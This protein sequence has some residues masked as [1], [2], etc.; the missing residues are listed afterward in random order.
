[1]SRSTR[2]TSRS[3]CTARPGRAG[4]RSTPPTRRSASPT[5]PPASWSP[6]RTR[7]RRSR[8][9]RR[10]CACSAPACWTGRSPTSR[11]SSPP[12]VARRSA[13][14]TAPS[15]SAPTTSPRTGSPTT[16]SACPSATSPAC[17]RARASTGSS[18]SSPPATASPSSRGPNREP[19]RGP[20]S[21]DQDGHRQ[22]HRR[23]AGRHDRAAVRRRLRV[24]QGRGPLAAR[25]GAGAAR[26]RRPQARPAAPTGGGP[27]AGGDG[28]APGGRRAPAIR[29]RLGAVRRATDQGRPWGVR[30]PPRERAGRGGGRHPPARGDRPRDRGRRR[31]ARLGAAQP[32]RPGGRAAGGRPGRTAARCAALRRGPPGDQCPLRAVRCDSPA[33]T[34]RAR[35][36]AAGGAR[37]RPRWAR[38]AAPGGR[39]GGKMA[40]PWRVA[41]LRDRRRPGRHR[42]LAAGRGGAGRGGGPAGPDGAD[43]DGGGTVA[44][45]T[46][47]PE[48]S[49][50]PEWFGKERL[51]K[52]SEDEEEWEPL[53]EVGSR[54]VGRGGLVVLPTDTVYGLGCDPFNA[55]AVSALF[56]A[57]GRGRNLPLPVL[58]HNWRQA[59]GLVEE[60]TEQ[61][62]LLIAE[63]WPGPLT[64]VLRESPG[65]GWDLGYSRGTVAVRMPKHEFALALIERTGPL[66]VTSANRSG[67]PTPSN[68]V[69]IVEQLGGHVDVFFDNGPSSGGAA[70]TIVDLSGEQARVLRE[71]AIP[72]SEI[73]RVIGERLADDL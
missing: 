17:S 11:P 62:K 14:W 34:G 48:W 30:A 33:A 19:V 25:G 66:A 9:G 16:A 40:R 39:P 23:R 22:H 24:R 20:A 49:D 72:A 53:V 68:V 54:I 2:P 27:S 56:I 71:G 4:S 5:C 47:L 29:D 38:R 70:S 65:I 45:V 50:L 35:A 6:C 21:D 15:A 60:V 57:K 10:R 44:S 51:I 58:V 41:G 55:S 61:A 36:R 46:D 64:I 67:V 13:R 18:R 12:S 31:G 63:F 26:R 52:V 43:P 73:E 7:S 69:E 3:T 37:R 42:R 1:M 32:Q 59:I 8:T 28:G